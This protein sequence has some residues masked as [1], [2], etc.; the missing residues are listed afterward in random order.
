MIEEGD[1]AEQR[2]G[3]LRPVDARCGRARRLVGE[4]L[5]E[6]GEE[7]EPLVLEP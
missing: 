6:L 5:E 1:V 2:R 4:A 3:G 7:V